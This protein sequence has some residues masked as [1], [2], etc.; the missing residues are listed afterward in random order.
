M[1]TGSKKKIRAIGASLGVK[2][3]V[4]KTLDKYSKITVEKLVESNKLLANSI[5]NF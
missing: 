3:T 2:L 5:V 1:K 4:D